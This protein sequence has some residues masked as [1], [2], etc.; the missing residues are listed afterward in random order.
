MDGRSD[1][2]L[3]RDDR[4]TAIHALEFLL[5]LAFYVHYTFEEMNGVALANSTFDSRHLISRRLID[6]YTVEAVHALR[7]IRPAYEG[8]ITGVGDR[9]VVD[10]QRLVGAERNLVPF[11]VVGRNNEIKIQSTVTAVLVQILIRDLGSL[12]ILVPGLSSRIPHRYA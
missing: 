11:G 4:V 9:V 3:E 1:G 12:D 7:D 6:L 8:V 10:D 5:V 2:Q